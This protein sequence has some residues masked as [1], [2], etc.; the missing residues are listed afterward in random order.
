MVD[1]FGEGKITVLELKNVKI[2]HKGQV[3]LS[4]DEE[5]L[6]GQF[7]TVMGRSGS[8]QSTLLNRIVGQLPNHF[9]ATGAL[10]LNGK[11]LND[12]ATERR[13][14]GLMY[15]DALLFPHMTV[16]QNIAFG[17]KQR[18]NTEH[19]IQ[20][21]LRR[22]DL[23]GMAERMPNSLS[24]GQQSRV[25]LLRLIASEPKAILLDEPFSN[26]DEDVK[27]TTRQFVL[28]QLKETS[29]PVVMVTHDK[30]DAS[31]VTGKLISLSSPC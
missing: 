1:V 12:V 4:V 15:Q 13:Q 21:Y 29:V 17:M 9:N 28:E 2:S 7:L 10:L 31:S 16:A 30:A 14:I 18:K 19:I 3:I 6:P 23:E 5:V 26:L 22:V 25:S 11:P 24:G 20:D 27:M 8:G